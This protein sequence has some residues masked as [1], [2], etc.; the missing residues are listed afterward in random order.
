MA[1]KLEIKKTPLKVPFYDLH[2]ARKLKK[3]QFTEFTIHS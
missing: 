3:F 1:F 2:K